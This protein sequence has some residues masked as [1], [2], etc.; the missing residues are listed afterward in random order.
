M[1]SLT[2]EPHNVVA[3]ADPPVG[4]GVNEPTR[5]ER[6]HR[7]KNSNNSGVSSI[8]KT[9]ISSEE[10]SRTLSTAIKDTIA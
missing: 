7:S 10:F 1:T 4:N 3:E 5:T 6:V 2:V 8:Q 9:V